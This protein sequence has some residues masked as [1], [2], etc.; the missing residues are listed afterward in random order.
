MGLA[1]RLEFH[2]ALVGVLGSNN[3]YFQPPPNFQMTYP[4]IVY[5]RDDQEVKRGD[6]VVYNVRQRYQVTYI[7]T[8]PDGDSI[9]GLTEFPL[10]KFSR[11]FAT[12]GLNHDVFSIYY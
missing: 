2:T 12:S 1:R 4:C 3:V 6:N 11:H 8:N 5:S 9:D 7:D 10:S